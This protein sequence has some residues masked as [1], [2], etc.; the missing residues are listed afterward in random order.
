MIYDSGDDI[1]ELDVN[2][3]KGE[4]T[5]QDGSTRFKFL[6]GPFHDMVFRVWPPYDTI[7][8]P[9]GTTYD[10]HPPHNLKKSSKWM[11][12]YNAIDSERKKQEIRDEQHD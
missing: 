5:L 9:D 3:V 1:V 8:W 6:G 7:V 11:Y 10:I 4:S 2:E 12:V